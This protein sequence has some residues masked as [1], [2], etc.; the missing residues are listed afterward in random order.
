[1]FGKTNKMNKKLLNYISGFFIIL[2]SINLASAIC[3]EQTTWDASCQNVLD[4]SSCDNSF[5]T[6]PS[7]CE[8]TTWC[9]TGTCVNQI[10]GTCLESSAAT[11]PSDL[12]GLWID[13]DPRETPQCQLGCCQIDGEV[14]FVT[15]TQCVYQSSL[16]DEP[17]TPFFDNSIDDPQECLASANPDVKGACV[18][19]TSRGR[20]CSHETRKKCEEDGLDFYEGI[21]CSSSQLRTLCAPTDSTRCVNK[22]E[23]VYF[24]DSCGNTANI[25]DA[26]RVT[27]D[28]YW[29]YMVEWEDSCAVNLNDPNSIEECGNC[30]YSLGTV[31]GVYRPGEDSQ[32]PDYGDYVCRDLR[33]SYDNDGDGEKEI[34]D[35]GEMWCADSG[36]KD[37]VPGK[38]EIQLLCNNGEVTAIPCLGRRNEI[39]AEAAIDDGTSEGYTQTSCQFNE[40]RDCTLQKQESDC[41][42]AGDCQWVSLAADPNLYEAVW[43]ENALDLDDNE[44]GICVPENPPGKVFWEEEV[45]SCLVDITCT[46]NYEKKILD[47][48]EV[49]DPEITCLLD[50]N[51][52][53][54]LGK[55]KLTSDWQEEMKNMCSALGDCGVKINYLDID[56]YYSWKDL[57]IGDYKSNS[58]KDA[59][60]HGGG[61]I[62]WTEW[63]VSG[64]EGGEGNGDEDGG[65]EP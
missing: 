56:G 33:C 53:S 16:L 26:S 44:K 3:C 51:D 65:F 30:M 61:E 54:S 6:D 64:E 8:Q 60:F 23:E 40:W 57:F 9:K 14:S 63:W 19:E 10:Q 34:Y 37:N 24:I 42:D 25:Y 52:D 62:P 39:C 20:D 4:I 59:D 5:K 55:T 18:S 36:W 48:W 41:D 11:C 50:G 7:S 17:T 12:G 46:V 45:Q 15:E 38:E 35:Q 47:N 43:G 58:L 32:R 27:N 31:C 22:K 49:T 21:L 2:I 28:E 1:M 29:T 13:A